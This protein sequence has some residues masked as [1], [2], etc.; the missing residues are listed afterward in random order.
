MALSSIGEGCKIQMEPIIQNIISN[1]V[2]P[3]INDPVMF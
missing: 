2:L 3:S 1:L